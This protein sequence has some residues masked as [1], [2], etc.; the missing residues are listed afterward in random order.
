M[1]ICDVS[2]LALTHSTIIDNSCAHDCYAHRYEFLLG[3]HLGLE[4]SRS[5]DTTNQFSKIVVPVFTS[6]I[7]LCFP[8]A[9]CHLQHSVSLIWLV[10]SGECS[11]FNLSSLS[12]IGP[13]LQF[14]Y[15]FLFKFSQPRVLGLAGTL[16]NHSLTC[17]DHL[18]ESPFSLLQAL[19]SL[20]VINLVAP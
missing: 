14:L 12:L 9:K 13:G 8:L 18:S 3:I 15:F 4:S 5:L 19:D 6:T 11:K 7:S 1:N 17:W 20:L 2:S 16:G 10:L